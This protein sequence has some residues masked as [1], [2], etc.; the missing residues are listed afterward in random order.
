MNVPSAAQAPMQTA[1]ARSIPY[2]LHAPQA[3][4]NIS[5]PDL[6]PPPSTSAQDLQL[7]KQEG[8]NGDEIEIQIRNMW[9]NYNLPLHIDLRAVAYETLNV[10]INRHTGILELRKR[11]PS[12]FAKIS[13]NGKVNILGCRSE[14]ECMKASRQIARI[15]QRSMNK[16][17]ETIRMRNYQ[18]RNVMATCNMPFGIKIEEIARKFPNAQYEPEINTGLI[19]KIPEPK[20]T[21][22]VHTT[23]SVTI[24]GA[25]SEHSCI[26][27]IHDVYPTLK[28]FSCGDRFR[29]HIPAIRQLPSFTVNRKRSNP[30]STSAY[31]PIMNKRSRATPI[32]S[33]RI[34]ATSSVQCGDTVD[35]SDE[36]H[37]Y[38]DDCGADEQWIEV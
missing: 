22:T 29:D 23:G 6:A 1:S 2:Q 36:E 3:E 14:A 18:I 20:A 12:C 4:H 31:I 32:M 28:E 25:T 17:E 8:S 13:S 30:V 10:E 11:N 35:F 37:L 19:W 24:T 21:L 26:Q 7:V 15:I 34:G 33:K 9:C 27:V 16:L 5:L 38:E